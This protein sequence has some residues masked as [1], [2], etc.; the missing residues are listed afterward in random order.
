MQTCG[1]MID[2]EDGCAAANPAGVQELSRW[3]G[4]QVPLCGDVCA[5]LVP[6]PCLECGLEHCANQFAD[7]FAQPEC[8]L[9]FRCGSL[10]G[11]D[12]CFLA[13][14]D[15]YPESEALFSAFLVCVGQ[16]CLGGPCSGKF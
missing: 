6:G 15:K 8:F 7:C 3:L 13:C 11:D 1:G 9:R 2:C 12:A 4:C 14:D 16:H 5:S 10:C